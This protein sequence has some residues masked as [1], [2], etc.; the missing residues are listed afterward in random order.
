LLED[1]N[2]QWES[3]AISGLTEK[4][5]PVQGYI[6]IRNEMGRYIRYGKGQEEFY[7]TSQDPREWTNQIDNP[8]YATAI[9]RLRAT[10]PKL[11]EMATPMSPVKRGKRDSD[12]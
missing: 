1:P 3:T 6:T 8:E 12:H 7:D 10:V 2:A 11:S 4:N 5:K 9:E